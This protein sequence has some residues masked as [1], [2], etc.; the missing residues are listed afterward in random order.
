M[1]G[2]RDLSLVIVDNW[3]SENIGAFYHVID[4][5]NRGQKIFRES[6]EI[7]KNGISDYFRY[8]VWKKKEVKKGVGP[9]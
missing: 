9:S 8:P 5:G 6:V 7:T 2:F 4:L 1:L 3:K